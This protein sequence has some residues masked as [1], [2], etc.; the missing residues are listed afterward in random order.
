MKCASYQSLTNAVEQEIWATPMRKQPPHAHQKLNEAFQESRVIVILGVVKTKKWQAWGEMSGLC[1]ETAPNVTEGFSPAIPIQWRCCYHNILSGDGLSFDRTEIPNP[2]D[3]GI[4]VNN[5]RNCQEVDPSIG[6]R[7]CQWM[8]DE[9]ESEKRHRQEQAQ[10]KQDQ[11]HHFFQSSSQQ[12]HDDDWRGLLN[13]VSKKGTPLF[14]CHVGSRSYNLHH[15]KSDTDMFVIC[16]APTSELVSCFP[17]ETTI[18]N[19]DGFE[20]DFTLHEGST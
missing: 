1:D 17:P 14:A 6:E 3:N 10:L 15:E 8:T 2:L 18:K 19:N 7:M 5:A 13:E 12:S 4:S 11:L 16:A 20:P 9:V